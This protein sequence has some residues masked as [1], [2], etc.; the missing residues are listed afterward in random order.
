MLLTEINRFALSKTENIWCGLEEHKK[1][2]LQATL[3]HSPAAYLSK[4]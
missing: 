2:R 3:L 1:T 4:S